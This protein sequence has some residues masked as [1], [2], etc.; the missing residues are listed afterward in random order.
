MESKVPEVLDLSIY[1]DMFASRMPPQEW[2]RIR[3]FR[4]QPNFLDGVRKHEGIMQPFFAHNFILNRVVTEIWRFQML[5][6]ALY[7]DSTRDPDDARSGLTVA[8]LQRICGKLGLASP[9]RVF[10]FLNVM[11]VGGYLSSVR[12]SKDARVIHLVPTARFMAI[13]EEWNDN[14]FASIDAAAGSDLV[15]QRV[16]R[17]QLGQEMRTR[18]AI[19]LLDGW[20]P[21]DPFPEGCHFASS[22]GGW[23]LMERVVLDSIQDDW[24]LR[25]NP[26][27]LSIRSAASQFGC[28]RTNLLRLLDEGFEMGLVEERPRNGGG[29]RFSKLMISAFLT[30]MASFLG[31]FQLHTH[32]ALA[33]A[34]T[35]EI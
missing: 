9:G 10:A 34:A 14:I 4:S 27:E 32:A 30:F 15:G 11:K 1:D 12:S 13:V 23:L 16:L 17:P 6:F 33:A 28:S 2:D 25:P 29:I 24:I 22:D 20:L 19:G 21:L 26:V 31:Y 3:T 7:L 5:V 35:G 18:G 8:N